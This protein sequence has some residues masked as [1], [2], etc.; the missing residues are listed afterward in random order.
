MKSIVFDGVFSNYG[1]PSPQKLWRDIIEDCW[2][3]AC[4]HSNFSVL[5]VKTVTVRERKSWVKLQAII[6][7]AR[8]IYHPSNLKQWRMQ[9]HLCNHHCQGRRR[10]SGGRSTRM[11]WIQ[12]A[13]ALRA[14]QEHV[15][16]YFSTVE[17]CEQWSLLLISLQSMNNLQY[18]QARYIIIIIIIVI[19]QHGSASM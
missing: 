14:G 3:R 2:R 8:R 5:L 12:A 19:R 7:M 13:M 6:A 16:V 1:N 4:S 18:M 10:K 9:L 11:Q 15:P 17:T